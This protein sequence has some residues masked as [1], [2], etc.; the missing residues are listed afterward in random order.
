MKIACIVGTR[1]NFMKIAPLISE[2]DK[3]KI[4]HILIHTGQHYDKK[5][6]HLFFDELGIPK[7][8]INLEVGSGSYGE[9]TGTIMIK[10][11]KALKEEK[12][13]LVVVVG[14]VNSTLAG[15]LVAKQLGISVAHVESGLRSFDLSMPEEINRMVTDR[16]SDYLFTNEE[17]ANKNLANEG[18]SKDKIH[19]CGNVMIDTLL[20][21]KEKAMKSDIL[22]KLN[23]ENQK[24]CA[25]TLHR[26]SNVDNK[27][28]LQ[29]I[30]SM[31]ET[32]QNGITV[33]FPIHPRTKKN[34]SE[35]GL[36]DQL[37]KLDK[38]IISEPLGYLDFL[39]LLDK[40]T[41]VLT[42]SGGIQ[43][44]TTVL[45]VPCIT[46]RDNTERPVTVDE[47]T[48]MLV[49]TN[50]KKVLETAHKLTEKKVSPKTPKLWDGK[51]AERIVRVLMER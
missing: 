50:P 19:F 23:I 31:L 35:F 22:K 13:D 10:L 49:S 26:P 44:E 21:H 33:V 14:D 37:K 4:E 25:V 15:A 2:L 39:H 12:P 17:S 46:F 28:Q 8:D 40:S 47:G 27:E 9:Q 51:A 29:T 1:P 45:G 42:D 7:P 11:E 3:R 5:M 43:E 18:I 16:I 34:I 20:K 24:Y 38:V 30:L 6:S 48:N 36:E 32:L 41:F